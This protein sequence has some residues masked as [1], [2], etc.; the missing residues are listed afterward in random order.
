MTTPACAVLTGWPPICSC[1]EAAIAEEAVP[2]PLQG[3]LRHTSPRHTNNCLCI[4][5]NWE[6]QLL[7]ATTRLATLAWTWH[8]CSCEHA[9]QRCLC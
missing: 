3:A 1:V 7:R 9:L 6:E 4:V 2:T 8:L 5:H